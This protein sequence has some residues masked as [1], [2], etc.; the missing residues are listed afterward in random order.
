MSLYLRREKY[1]EAITLYQKRRY[2]NDTKQV[3]ITGREE[4]N[5]A[6]GHGDRRQVKPLQKL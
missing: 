3:N 2:I 5:P 6:G 4:K 1:V